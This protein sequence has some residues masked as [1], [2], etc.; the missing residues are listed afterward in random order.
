MHAQ[1]FLCVRV[2]ISWE[3]VMILENDSF[4]IT[5]SRNATIVGYYC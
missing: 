2:L 5:V 3:M 4:C 1:S